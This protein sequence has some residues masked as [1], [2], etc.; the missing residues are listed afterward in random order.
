M[1]RSTKEPRLASYSCVPCQQ[2]D[3]D[4]LLILQVISEKLGPVMSEGDIFSLVSNAQE[5]DMD[6]DAESTI[7]RLRDLTGRERMAFGEL[8]RYLFQRSLPQATRFT[9]GR[10]ELT[11]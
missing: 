2:K 8:C 4:A 9:R 3:T 11:A 5:F 1:P 7:L 6:Q 10:L